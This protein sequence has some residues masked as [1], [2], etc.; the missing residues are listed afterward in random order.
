MERGAD[1]DQP[2]K[3]DERPFNL[4]AGN[5]INTIPLINYMNLRCMAATVISKYKI[6]YRNQLP[7]LLEKF[8]RQ[9]EP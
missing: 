1:L 6:P 5:P 3:S 4:I 2:N 7:K 9:H 8:V